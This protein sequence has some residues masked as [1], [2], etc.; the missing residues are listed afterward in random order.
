MEDSLEKRLIDLNLISENELNEVKDLMKLKDYKD[1]SLEDILIEEG[2]I[3]EN[4]L[5][6]IFHDLY[7]IPI[8]NLRNFD[9]NYNIVKIFSE[10]FLKTNKVLPL[11]LEEEKIMIAMRDPG[12]ILVIDDIEKMTNLK[13]EIYLATSTDILTALNKIFNNEYKYEEKIFSEINQNTTISENDNNFNEIIKN[14]PIVKLVNMILKQ[15]VLE[16]VSDIHIEPEASKVRIRYRI[17]GI[18]ENKML[19][20][21]QS[22]NAIISR[23]KIISALD[24][25]ENRL[26]QDGRIE[27]KINGEKID[28]RVSIIPTIYGEKAVIRLLK[29]E[30]SLI[31]LQNIGFTENNLNKFKKLIKKQKGIILVTGPTGSG[32]STTLFSALNELKDES[33]NIVTIEDPVEYRISGFNQIQL[34]KKINFDFPNALKSILRQDPDIIMVGEIRD[35]ETASIAIRAA[36]TGHLVLTTLHTNDAVSSINRLI[37]MDIPPYLVSSSVIGVIA[38]RLIRRLCDNCK[39]KYKAFKEEIKLFKDLK[40][41]EFLYKA[42]KCNSCR[43]I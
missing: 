36:L 23:V 30:N 41:V 32:K 16:R 5:I 7:N 26:P 4:K 34:N 40:E 42:K 37:D 14:A 15:A 13:A 29:K 27:R 9:I 11:N 18:L 2:L 24:I 8:I 17:D 35:K 22:I 1:Y 39:T 12:E 20:P 6:D 43:N 25:T 21:Y 19:L 31:D 10:E 33:K 38:Q 28:M 3:E